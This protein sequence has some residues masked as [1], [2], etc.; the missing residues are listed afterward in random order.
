MFLPIGKSYISLFFFLSLGDSV[1]K[2]YMLLAL[3]V[4]IADTPKEEPGH[5]HSGYPNGFYNRGSSSD[6]SSKEYRK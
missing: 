6:P 3:T 4:D 5:L 2:L 1:A